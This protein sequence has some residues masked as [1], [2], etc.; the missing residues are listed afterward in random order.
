MD[1]LPETN[2]NLNVSKP[3]VKPPPIVADVRVPMRE[4]QLITGEDCIYKRTSIGTK[5]FP[6]TKEK[7]EFCVKALKEGL[8]EFHSFKSK[9]NKLFTTYLYGLPRLSPDDILNDLKNYNLSPTSVTEIQT[10]YSSIDDAVYK[11]QFD[12]KSFNPSYL[13]NV[14]S[15]CSVIIKWKKHKPSKSDRPT[16][17]WNCLMYGHGGD[18]CNRKPA[19]MSCAK[20]HKTTECPLTKENKRLAVFSCFNCKQAGEQRSDHA[21]NDIN[22]PLRKRYLEIRQKVTTNH[23]KR[24]QIGRPRNAHPHSH[25]YAAQQ[26]TTSSQPSGHTYADAARKNDCDLFSID[27]LFNIFAS[28]LDDLSRCTNKVQQIQVVMSLLKYAHDI[29]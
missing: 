16:Q 19:C 23:S 26:C 25:T 3:T 21:A 20:M 17:C 28:A 5:I 1:D 24:A 29:K 9:E 8:I 15:I 4:I 14:K 18:H 6:Q 27:E 2:I 22:C 11:V 7:Y 10:K 13:N 12:R